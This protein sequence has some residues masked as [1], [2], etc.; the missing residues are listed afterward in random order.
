LKFLLFDL[1]L[2]QNKINEYM[3]KMQICFGILYIGSFL[4]CLKV[5]KTA[6]IE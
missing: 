4:E 6:K 5:K 3:K 2:Q 1:L